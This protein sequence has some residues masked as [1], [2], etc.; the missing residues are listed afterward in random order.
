[1]ELPPGAAR[2]T[3][4]DASS[5]VRAALAEA[6]ASAAERLADPVGTRRF[7]REDAGASRVEVARALPA[8]LR[9]SDDFLADPDARRTVEITGRP[10]A[11]AEVPR[12][13]EVER[14]QRSSRAVA[15]R[16]GANPDRIAMW[17]VLLGILLV[18]IAF[19][20]GSAGAVAM[21]LLSAL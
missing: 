19:T 18:L 2:A 15:D 4:A 16:L 17:A 9:P 10:G 5:S 21:P 12:L 6:S 11:L 7:A 8:S 20:S 1:M 3:D 14:H 13:H